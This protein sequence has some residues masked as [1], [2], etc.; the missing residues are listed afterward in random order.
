MPDPRPLRKTLP[1]PDFGDVPEAR[2]R[3]LSAVKGKDTRPELLI[4]RGL[5]ALGYRYRLH[6][7]ELPGRPDL[8]F[9]SR[10]AVVEV[11]G[12]FWHRHG[13]CAN[14]VLPKTRREWWEQ[15][16]AGNVARDAANEAA[17][18]AAGWRLLVVWECDVRGDLPATLER[19]REFLGPPGAHG[20]A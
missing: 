1:R 4:R 10:R 16:L 18:A 11:R 15:K 12:C 17:L 14:S 3:N 5:H 6:V 19:V 20:R 9:P 8:V 7:R 2:R 13:C